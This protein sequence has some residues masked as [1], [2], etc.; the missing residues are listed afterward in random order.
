[1]ENLYKTLSV[2]LVISVLLLVG[3]DSVTNSNLSDSNSLNEEPAGMAQGIKPKP[4]NQFFYYHFSDIQGCGELVEVEGYAQFIEKYTVVEDGVKTNW[5]SHL[6]VKGI[7]TGQS[8]GAT[9]NYSDIINYNEHAWGTW[10][11]FTNTFHRNMKMVGKG[12]V[13]NMNLHAAY[14]LTVT[15]DGDKKV[16]VDEL[17][18]TCK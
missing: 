5:H 4:S 7:A 6:N 16:T 18:V 10:P 12:Q 2:S 17:K 1:M 8:S 13:P 15:P 3:C 14:H 11:E 9:Y